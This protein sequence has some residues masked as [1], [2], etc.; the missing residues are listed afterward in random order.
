MKTHSLD[1][2]R[3]FLKLMIPLSI[4]VVF[5]AC[6]KAKAA[7]KTTDLQ[8]S[9]V[10]PVRLAAVE[11]KTVTHDIVGSGM[12]ASKA[13][14]RPSFKTGGVIAKMYVKEGDYV[15][16]GQLLATLDLTE[17]NAQVAQAQIG[18]DKAERDLKRAKNLYADTVATLEQVQNATT[19]ADVARRNVE[20]AK[21][22]QRFSEIRATRNGTV[23][24]KL[25]NEGELAGPGTPVFVI[26]EAVSNDWVVR[27]GVSDRDWAALKVG[28]TARVTFDAYPNQS[29]SGRVTKLADYADPMSGTF[30][31]EITV[32][33]KADTRFVLGMYA[34]VSMTPSKASNMTLVP[35]ESLVEGNGTEGVVF[36]PNGTGGV[37]KI[38]VKIVFIG[39][40]EIGVSGLDGVTMVVT[41]GSS[42]LTEKSRVKVVADN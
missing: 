5:E 33:P 19:G 4:A 37:V 2:T 42:Y 21:F 24:R 30:A 10:I 15:R 20:I 38:P 17:I 1:F 41:E 16:T 12:L 34:Q 3:L 25:M 40:K 9:E 28:N 36:A 32:T 29:F 8:D 26:N 7:D 23:L 11:R 14:S 31:V 39:G 35:I 18:V 13:E 27:V 6:G 22:N